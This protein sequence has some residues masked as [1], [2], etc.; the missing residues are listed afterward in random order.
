MQIKNSNLMIVFSSPS[1]AGKTTI[2][3]ELLKF[4][5]KLQMSVSATT[6]PKRPSEKDG[7][8]YFFYSK[9]EF[10]YELKNEN[11]LEYALVFDNYYGTPK[12]FVQKT[13]NDG[14][15][16]VFDIDW[17]GAKQL[18][19]KVKEE[20]ISFFIL[21]PN[22]K[23]LLKRLKTRNE[24]TENI[25]NSRMSKAKSEMSHWNEYDYVIINDNLNSCIAEI[26]EIIKVERKKRFRQNTL[27]NFVRSL[28]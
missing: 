18:S 26:L 12:E 3:R 15:D 28:I 25:V 22:K 13:L 14:F 10:D 5:K 20:L 17:Q 21:P 1:G 9:K 27:A 4:D 7:V 19:H 11:F 8:D 16:V 24:D 6:R 23:E 2:C